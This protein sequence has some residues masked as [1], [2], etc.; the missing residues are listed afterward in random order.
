MNTRPKRD[1]G[2]LTTEHIAYAGLADLQSAAGGAAR[3]GVLARII[4]A[5]FD[6]YYVRSRQIPL[7][8][9]AAFEERDWP[10]AIALSQE[11][12]AIY[13]L[14][15]SKAVPVLELAIRETEGQAQFWPMVESAFGELVGG[16]YEADLAL[17]YLAS[18]R[19]WVY[20]DRWQP[21]PYDVA[22]SRPL[23]TDRAFLRSHRPPDGRMTP[24]IAD[25]LLDA[26][27]L[28]TPFRDRPGDA[29]AVAERINR[30]LGLDAAPVLARVEV[31]TAGFYR[32]RGAYVVGA[33]ELPER[34]VPMALALLNGEE[35]V[36]VDAVITRS[37]T[38]RHVF[39]SALANFHVTERAYHEVVAY[40]HGLMPERPLGQHY[41]TVGYN[42]VGKM[43]VMQEI[44]GDL[45]RT[46]QVFDHAPGPRGS[47]AIGFTAPGTDY[48]LKVIRDTPTDNYKWE[49]FD[50][51]ASVL[52]K[53][54]AVH[55]LNRSGSMLDNILYQTVA[56]PSSLFSD[57]LLDDL[58]EAASGSIA[59]YR[60]EVM[61]RHLI[62]QRKM[63][64]LPLFLE[65]CS[66]REAE[67]AVIRL[68]QCI[69]NN[70]ATGVFNRDLDGRNYGV[71]A[72]RFVY[73]FDYDAILPLSE[74][75]V[76]TNADREFGEEDVP[77]WV[78]EEGPV[79]LPEELEAHLRLPDKRLRRLFRE[80]HGELLTAA[81]WERMQRLLAEGRVPRVR[82]Y[83][84][85]TQLARSQP[86]EDLTLRTPG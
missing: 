57:A 28:E 7:L 48:V 36:T 86:E 44:R 79:F 45:A 35:G 39:S 73:L 60:N 12:I 18:I 27:G 81:W 15:I 80:A 1:F 6:D 25:A 22:R 78:F 58:L 85:S 23:P 13:S 41:S 72:L 83:P 46:E 21:I 68:G 17:A 29:A 59:F 32:N 56:L 47:V 55:E 37:S 5:V 10:T 53:Y 71:S 70:A 33:L 54:S 2:T 24:A 11:R 84:R 34:R 69:R 16:R 49:R 38:L 76:R 66:E 62:V 19:R 20:R 43:A 67:T 52:E 50:G 77:D 26:P 61:F 42:H 75:K 82:T 64:P 31:M 63:V 8:A 9:K 4:L 74:V 40:L 14:S 51:V 65:R 30:E 3:A